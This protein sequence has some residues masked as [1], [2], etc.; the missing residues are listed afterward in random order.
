[1][2]TGDDNVSGQSS[3]TPVEVTVWR[4]VQWKGAG[5]LE[6]ELEHQELHLDGAC[7]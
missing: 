2:V 7:C 4:Y 6:V 3:R 5:G 1:M